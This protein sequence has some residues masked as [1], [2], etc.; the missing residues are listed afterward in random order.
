MTVNKMTPRYRT[1]P[2][3]NPALRRGEGSSRRE[4]GEMRADDVVPA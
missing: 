1:T 3:I 4:R 2:E